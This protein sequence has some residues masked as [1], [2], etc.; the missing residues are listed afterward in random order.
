ML[1]PEKFGH[2]PPRSEVRRILRTSGPSGFTQPQNETKA[3]GHWIVRYQMTA[4]FWLRARGT[5]PKRNWRP[6]ARFYSLPAMQILTGPVH[7]STPCRSF[8]TGRWVR[9]GAACWV[10]GLILTV[11]QR[12]MRLM[13]FPVSRT[14]I[15]GGLR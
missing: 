13:I 12:S 6:A 1:T 10:Y 8:G 9:A 15:G 5:K 3:A 2:C 4:T 11:D 7:R 14:S